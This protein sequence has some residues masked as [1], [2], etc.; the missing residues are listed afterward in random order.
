MVKTY[1]TFF[2]RK[3]SKKVDVKF[4]LFALSLDPWPLSDNLT[5]NTQQTESTLLYLT[6][7]Q[8]TEI[9]FLQKTYEDIT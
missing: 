1:R 7:I 8:C 3:S 5:V 4:D 6:K 9:I 2:S